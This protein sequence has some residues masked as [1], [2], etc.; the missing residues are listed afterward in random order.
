MGEGGMK[1][2]VERGTADF[3]WRS[4][5]RGAEWGTGGASGSPVHGGAGRKNT[6]TEGSLAQKCFQ[7]PGDLHVQADPGDPK[8]GLE[9]RESEGSLQNKTF[10]LFGVEG[11]ER[12]GS[13]RKEGGES[14]APSSLSPRTAHLNAIGG[15]I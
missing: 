8:L 13:L 11:A 9:T 14:G 12:E 6:F 3:V 5:G 2:W 7:N 10:Y 4:G 1:I 15:P